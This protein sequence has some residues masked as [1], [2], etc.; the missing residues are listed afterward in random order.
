MKSVSP[1]RKESAFTLLE[2]LTVTA[3]LTVLIGI[4]L[5]ATGNFKESSKQIKCISQLRSIGLALNH[6]ANDNGNCYPATYGPLRN[7]PDKKTWMQKA[8]PYADMPEDSMGSLPLPRSTGIFVCPAFPKADVEA[9]EV[10][11]R[12][13][14]A[15]VDAW[16]YRRQAINVS[17][18]FLVV[19]TEGENTEVF[20][21]KTSPDVARR[22]LGKS[23]NFLY[24][25]GHVECL[26]D[27]V[28]PEDPRWGLKRDD[29]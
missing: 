3:L 24:A 2:L 21:I 29:N 8:A 5:S 6:F 25:D 23:A 12:Y 9:R 11:Y 14:L 20:S 17:K 4:L 1:S 27:Y 15:L 19:E 7:P 18:F 28:G 13:N 10:S 22:H 26:R 16:Q